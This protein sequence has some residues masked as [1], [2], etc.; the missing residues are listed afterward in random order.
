M[1]PIGNEQ[2]CELFDS[3]HSPVSV[4]MDSKY[5]RQSRCYARDGTINNSTNNLAWLTHCFTL[6][7]LSCLR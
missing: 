4:S 3:K 2:M 1:T 6:M 5:C 7:M